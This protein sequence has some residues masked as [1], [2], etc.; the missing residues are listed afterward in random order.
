MWKI[1][2]VKKHVPEPNHNGTDEVK[3]LCSV[4]FITL[5]KINTKRKFKPGE[6]TS[7]LHYLKTLI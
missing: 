1:T 7:K 2:N 6:T 5:Q 4:Y 3:K